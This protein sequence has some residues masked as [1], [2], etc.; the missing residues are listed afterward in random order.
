VWEALAPALAAKGLLDATNEPLL[1]AYCA[2]VVRW[3]RAHAQLDELVTTNSRGTLVPHPLLAVIRE[4][5]QSMALLGGRFGL[6]PAD[7]RRV[8]ADDDSDAGRAIAE[9]L[10]ALAAAAVGDAPPAG[11]PDLRR[12]RR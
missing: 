7:R 1:A 6:T 2:A 5:E 8:D 12:G 4:A 9:R 3:R 11:A 10:S